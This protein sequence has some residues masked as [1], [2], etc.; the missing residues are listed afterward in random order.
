MC[1]EEGTME[2]IKLL[3]FLNVKSILSAKKNGRFY[4]RC[5]KKDAQD[6]PLCGKNK[7]MS[8]EGIQAL[9]K[10]QLKYN[11]WPKIRLYGNAW[12]CN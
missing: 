3:Y 1:L 7:Y 10:D 4:H 6:L 11:I 9:F 8:L 5:I 2:M 12:M